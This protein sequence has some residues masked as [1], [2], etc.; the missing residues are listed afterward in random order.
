LTSPILAEQLARQLAADPAQIRLVSRSIAAAL[1]VQLGARLAMDEPGEGGSATPK[2]LTV[3]EAAELLRIATG[4]LEHKGTVQPFASFRVKI[5]RRTLYDAARI[6]EWLRDPDGYR[7]RYAG[8]APTRPAGPGPR[9]APFLAP[10]GRG[11][12]TR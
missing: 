2:L 3:R 4:T 1:I 10:A 12:T 7:S 8:P 9:P 5:G 6:A 11:R